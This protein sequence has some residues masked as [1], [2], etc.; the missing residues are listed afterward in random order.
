MVVNAALWCS[1]SLFVGNSA[2]VKALLDIS[3]F[4]N[5]VFQSNGGQTDLSVVNFSTVYHCYVDETELDPLVYKKGNIFGGNLDLVDSDAD[6]YHIGLASVLIN[7][8]T[9]DVGDAELPARDLDGNPRVFGTTIDIGPYEL[10]Y[11]FD[12]D[13]DGMNDDWE[14]THFTSISA[15][16]EEDP[17]SDGLNNLGEFNAGTDPKTADTDN[18]NMPDG[19]EVDH[20]L[21]PL[22]DDADDDPD[23]DNLTNAK[24]FQY[25][26]DPHQRNCILTLRPGWNMIGMAETC[27][28]PFSDRG[29]ETVW[30][31][32][33]RRYFCV[34]SAVPDVPWHQQ[35]KLVRDH[36]Y[37]FFSLCGEQLILAPTTNQ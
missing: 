9:I 17:D 37:W 14:T 15:E 10:A 33:T 4:Y 27:D 18:D 31:W 16:A 3:H 34:N 30:A 20:G 26:T 5:C 23:A 21:D 22:V 12:R 2:G 24:E 13:E 28:A 35:G 8:G 1:N 7:A 29:S 11:Y 6:D 19:W 32:D 25:S 36:G